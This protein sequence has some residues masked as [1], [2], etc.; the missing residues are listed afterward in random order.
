MIMIILILITLLM[1]T[2]P[3]LASALIPPYIIDY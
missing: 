1:K 2:I 3:R